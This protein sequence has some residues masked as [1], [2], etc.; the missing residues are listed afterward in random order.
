MELKEQS[1]VIER[2]LRAKRL[3]ED[4]TLT[5]VLDSTMFDLYAQFQSLERPDQAKFS[6]LWAIHKALDMVVKRLEALVHNG[7]L[8]EEN[9]R[10]D[11][12]RND[13]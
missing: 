11:E 7:K 10:L 13:I 3:L 9:R 4:E 12:Q 8:E 6:E 1:Q 5:Y 2:G